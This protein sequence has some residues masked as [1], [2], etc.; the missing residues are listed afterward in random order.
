MSRIA[1]F[2]FYAAVMTAVMVPVSAMAKQ[3]PSVPAVNESGSPVFDQLRHEAIEKKVPLVIYLTGSSWCV[4]CNIF[5]KKHIKEPAFKKA[6]GREFIFWMV[7]TKQAPGRTPG[8]F[9]FQFVPEEAGNVVGCIGSKA[10]YVVFWPPA[11][12]ILD[13]VSGKMIKKMVSQGDMDKEG[14]PLPAVIEDCWKK[15]REEG[16]KAS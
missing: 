15:F 5:T 7:D 8:S 1:V 13:P 10:P 16:Q 14:K 4:Y 3:Q 12:I 11:V 6:A 9:I 2:M